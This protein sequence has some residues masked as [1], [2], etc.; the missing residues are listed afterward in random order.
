MNKARKL[1]HINMLKEEYEYRGGAIF[2]DC[3]FIVLKMHE[4]GCKV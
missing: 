4:G 2:I 3:P 1:G